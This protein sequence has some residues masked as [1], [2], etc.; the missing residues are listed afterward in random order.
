M[1]LAYQ[2]FEPGPPV[3]PA[4]RSP[5]EEDGWELPEPGLPEPEPLEPAGPVVDPGIGLLP[6]LE[7]PGAEPPDEPEEPEVP[8][9]P[10]LLPE[11]LLLFVLT[12]VAFTPEAFPQEPS[13]AKV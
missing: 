11:E 5:P 1:V 13:A 12:T 2:W 8:P 6:E 3:R 7:P 9:G 4:S 10:L